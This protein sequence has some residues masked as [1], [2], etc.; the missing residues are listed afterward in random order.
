MNKGK[1]ILVLLL[2]ALFFFGFNTIKNPDGSDAKW[3]DSSLPVEYY[4]NPS[5]SGLNESDVINAIRLSFEEW[6]KPD[7]T[8]V[9]SKYMGK[10]SSTTASPSDFVNN[11]FFITGKWPPELGGYGTIAV[12]TPATYSDGYIKDADIRFNAADFKWSTT[13]EKGKMD[14]QN[15]ATHEIGHLFGLDHTMVFGATM[16]PYSGP[17]DTRQRSIE[18]DDIKGI[19]YLYPA[20]NSST[21]G[22]FGSVCERSSDCK[23]GVC[24]ANGNS[25]MCSQTCDINET[26]SCPNGYKCYE[27]TDNNSYCFPGDNSSDLCKPCE[28]SDDC[29]SE[30]CLTDGN[31]SICSRYCVVS[32]SNCPAG[33]YCAELENGG[34]GCW[35]DNDECNASN[36]PKDLGEICYSLNE[37]KAGL[38]C[39]AAKAGDDSGK[40]YYECDPK[41]PQCPDNNKCITLTNNSGACMP[42]SPGYDAGTGDTSSSKDTITAND[43][44]SNDTGSSDIDLIDEL[45][46]L[47]GCECSIIF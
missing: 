29:S 35:P 18:E 45:N 41:R 33:Y 37:C 3:Q 34:G 27:S 16:Y 32:S 22:E 9:S 31:L 24:V 47:T 5:G 11:L 19:C 6:S 13:G 15:I 44:T 7:C 20:S 39:V 42:T 36:I 43:A 25:G 40:C 30:L 14:V 23:S 46:N 26:G 1:M 28:K 17:A 21:R 10:T 2:T 8:Y 38:I 4:I 12:C